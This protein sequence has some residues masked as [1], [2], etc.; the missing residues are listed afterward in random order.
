M[1]N[2]RCTYQQ[3]YNVS[4]P[5]SSLMTIVCNEDLKKNDYR[6]L[7]ILFTELDGWSEPKTGVSKDPQNFKQVDIKKISNLLNIDKKDVKK[8]LKILLNEFILDIG[9]T[10]K[11][12][13]GY[14]FTF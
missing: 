14:R 10:D 11:I 6:V 12:K 7:M 5:K 2:N 13:D 1:A 9:D 3:I 8:S 4:I